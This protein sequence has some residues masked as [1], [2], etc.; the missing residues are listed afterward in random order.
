MGR[1]S[2]IIWVGPKYNLLEPYKI[3]AKGYLI[4]RKARSNMTVETE[5]RVMQPQVKECQQA[6]EARG[7]KEQVFIWSL[8]K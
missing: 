6:P 7:G 3:E 2:W 1:S 8:W 5:S 4:D